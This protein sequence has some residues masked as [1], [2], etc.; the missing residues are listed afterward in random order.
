MTNRYDGLLQ[1]YDRE[2]VALCPY[3]PFLFHVGVREFKKVW[4]AG[5]RV[6]EIGCGDGHSALPFL[7]N[8]GA[9]MTLLDVSAAM[10][11][12]CQDNLDGFVG[13]ATFVCGDALKYIPQTVRQDIIIA[14]WTIHNFTQRQRETLLRQ[15]HRNLRPDGTFILLDKVYP[16][17]ST[18]KLLERQL[19]RYQDLPRDVRRA[20]VRHE[21]QDATD[22][23]RM[24]ERPLLGLLSE[25]GFRDM[26]IHDRVERDI[27]LT[28]RR[29]S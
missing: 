10:I 4:T 3:D 25:I 23:Y 14:A 24:D 18:D 15:I 13:R 29:R 8:T 26:R 17:P 2:I 12:A 7:A 16:G 22:T 6:L 1:S 11:S 5:A 9:H 19:V 21:R 27:V 20:I 28:A